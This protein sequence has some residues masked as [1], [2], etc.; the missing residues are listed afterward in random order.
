MSTRLTALAIEKIKGET[1]RREIADA[2]CPGL[3]LIVQASGAKS[4]AIRCRIDG[5]PTKF[6]LGPYPRFDLVAAR[7]QARGALE[8]VDRGID[9][10]QQREE[11]RQENTTRRLNTVRAVAERFRDRHMKRVRPRTWRDSW[12]A[13]DRY[14]L[15][16]LGDRLIES[17]RRHDLHDILDDLADKPGARHHVVSAVSSLFRWSL[18]REIIEANPAARMPR[19]KIG[20]RERAL[21]DEEIP[22]VWSVAEAV[23]YPFGPFV[24]LLLLTGCR[25][26]EIAGLQWSE[27]DLDQNTITVPAERY[28]TGR[29]LVVPL[30]PPAKELIDDLPRHAGGD[31]VFSTTGGRR[32][33]SGY[34]KM[35]RRFDATLAARCETDG[36]EPFDFDLHDLRRTVRTNLSA[37]RV[38]PHVAEAVLGHVVT[39]VQKHYYKWTYLDE[40]REAL[41]AWGRK[42]QS[43]IAPGNNVVCLSRSR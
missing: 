30:N 7:E 42:L 24:R 31:Y 12:S 10:R 27:I 21:S 38:P 22:I 43:L 17:I 9:P 20:V 3:Y 19:V 33:I 25:R 8:L 35:K 37:L 16:R 32:P 11:Q 6:T 29:T 23:S 41:E 39:G 1:S 40:K 5:K 26:S 4:W 34:S 18:D 14:V 13:L 15:G 36:R 2:G 28:K